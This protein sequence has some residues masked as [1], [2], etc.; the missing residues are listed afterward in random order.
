MSPVLCTRLALLRPRH[1]LNLPFSCRP[2][3]ASRCCRNDNRSKRRQPKTGR[4]FVFF[5][6]FCS[7]RSRFLREFPRFAPSADKTWMHGC[8]PGPAMP[9]SQAIR[10]YRPSLP[11][12]ARSAREPAHARYTIHRPTLP[13]GVLPRV[14]L[15]LCIRLS[16]A[17]YSFFVILADIAL[18]TLR[19]YMQCNGFGKSH[20]A[21]GTKFCPL[22][23]L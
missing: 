21:K 1:K 22:P 12:C 14:R 13:R 17:A 16:S 15:D 6:C 19:D 9:A 5:V 20:P 4:F 8:R 23:L 2:G 7:K 3:G 18:L 11:F 10:P